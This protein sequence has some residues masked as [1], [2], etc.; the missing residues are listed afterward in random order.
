M[1]VQGVTGQG[2]IGQGVIGFVEDEDTI[3]E[4]VTLALRQSGYE[5]RGFDDGQRAWEAFGEQLPDL[6]ILDIGVPRMDGLTICRKLR[7]RSE[8]LPIIF[9][10]SREEEFDRVLGLEI[11]ADDYLCKPFS[12]R[13]LLAR[14]KVLLRRAALAGGRVD[15]A[16]DSDPERVSKAGSLTLDLLRYT[17]TWKDKPLSVTVTEFLLLQALTR[18][19]GHVKTRDQ[20]MAQ[21]Y[22]D[23]TF[24]SDRTIDSHVKRL[25]RKL[26]ECD[27]GFAAI[28]TVYGL[29]Y[30]FVPDR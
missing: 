16:S 5:V 18:N 6:V 9:L 8:V 27:P 24:V 29:G 11:G 4:A 12:M 26:E 25:R 10:T 17:A 22:P 15:A 1:T 14:V 2:V 3:R 20:L 21:A 23:Q 19:P 13:E 28:E 30:R 7:A